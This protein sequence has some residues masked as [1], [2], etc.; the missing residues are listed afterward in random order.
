M[1]AAASRVDFDSMDLYSVLEVSEDATSEE[2]KRAYRKKALEHH[3]DKNPDDIEGA[4][5]RFN[6]VQEAYEILS[7]SDERSDYDLTRESESR[8]APEVPKPQPPPPFSPPGAWNEE[9]KYTAAGPQ[10]SWSEWLL[11]FAFRASRPTGYTRDA[12]RPEVYVYSVR[13]PYSPG[14]TARTIYEF[15]QSTQGLDFSK[16]D[17]S[18]TSFF[19]ILENFFVCLGLDE[20]LWHS[21][22]AHDVRS[23]P[24]FGCGHFVWTRD[25]WDLSDGEQLREVYRFYSFWSNFK[26]LK[27]FE[28]IAPYTCA[29]FAS[30][31]EVRFC[32]KANKPYQERARA[33]YNQ[34]I[35]DI[36]KA[37]KAH[38]PRYL[39]HLAVQAHKHATQG[40]A[41]KD[42]PKKRG[43]HKNK[44]KTTW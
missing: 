3:P 28:W 42:K 19:T 22:E 12:F 1:G 31:R 18:E 10:Q 15:V 5:R 20:Q 6:R 14:I 27:S 44:N 21:T 43:K 32:R 41:K 13:E 24:R 8:A 33:Q 4:T 35:Q 17:H 38:D 39:E 7:D 34:L 40:A 30:P 16:D 11:G 37:L 2:I 25:D 23:Y 26:T 36:V 29:Q 9:V